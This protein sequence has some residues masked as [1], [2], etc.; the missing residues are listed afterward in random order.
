MFYQDLSYMYEPIS[1]IMMSHLILHETKL[2]D[3]HKQK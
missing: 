2:I 1:N 3:D